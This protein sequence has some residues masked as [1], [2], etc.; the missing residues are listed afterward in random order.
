MTAAT[1]GDDILF[2]KL[3]LFEYLIRIFSRLVLS[4]ILDLL[5]GAWEILFLWIVGALK[6]MLPSNLLRQKSLENDVVLI[7][8][9]GGGLGR[10]IALRVRTFIRNSPIILII[11]I[12]F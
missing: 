10:Q 1:L 12:T 5:Y 8:G 9:A 7:T 2:G 6:A 4:K 3:N 11:I